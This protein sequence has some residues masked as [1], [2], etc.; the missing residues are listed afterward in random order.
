MHFRAGERQDGG[1]RETVDAEQRDAAVEGDGELLARGVPDDGFG[2]A[3]REARLADGGEEV[4]VEA[5]HTRFLARHQVP[6]AHA[7]LAAADAE[8][9]LHAGVNGEGVDA[10]G[11]LAGRRRVAAGPS[12]RFRDRGF[13]G[14]ERFPV[15]RARYGDGAVFRG[16]EEL[17]ARGEVQ[18]GYGGGVVHER[19][20]FLV[21]CV[22]RDGGAVEGGELGLELLLLARGRGFGEGVDVDALVGAAGC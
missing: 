12:L 13:D 21:L 10:R 2:L 15:A 3:G 4:F 6:Q 8:H 20:H 11:D 16:G 17:A 14:G 9:E 19:A 1:F 18:G 7:L 5:Q 22:L